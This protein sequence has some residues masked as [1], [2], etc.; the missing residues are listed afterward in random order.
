MIVSGLTA[1]STTSGYSLG[2]YTSSGTQVA[3]VKNSDG[4]WPSSY[5][6]SSTFSLTANSSGVATKT[7]TVSI[8][9]SVTG[10]ASMRLRLNSTAK[11]TEA[12]TIANVPVE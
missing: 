6:Y 3:K 12:V 11:Y 4:T 8:N 2:I 10:A 5:G 9:P 1:G 7:L